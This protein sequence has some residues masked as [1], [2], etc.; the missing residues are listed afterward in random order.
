MDNRQKVFSL[1]GLAARGRNLVSGESQVVE[2]IRDGSGFMVV[3]AEDASANTRKLF[4]DKCDYYEV[5]VFD[6]GS[7]EELGHAIGKDYRSSIAVC[8]E[9]LA[10]KIRDLLNA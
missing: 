4:H 6:F 3:V 1:L 10:N 8:E 5:P 9:G 2:A 7:K